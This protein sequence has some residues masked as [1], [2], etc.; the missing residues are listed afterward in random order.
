MP[1]VPHSV[2]RFVGLPGVSHRRCKGMLIYYLLSRR[3]NSVVLWKVCQCI[4]HST[5]F[6]G[7]YRTLLSCCW[8][9][10]G[11]HSS[12]IGAI[13][14]GFFVM[15]SNGLQSDCW[16]TLCLKVNW[17]NHSTPKS[18]AGSSIFIQAYPFSVPVWILPANAMELL[19][20]H[21]WCSFWGVTL[22]F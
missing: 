11:M 4:Y 13:H 7:Q 3:I 8:R 16:A 6:P 12:H 14:T 18:T 20:L 10:T 17:W 21:Q 22:K 9:F 15:L 5:D 2:Q 19:A 1:V